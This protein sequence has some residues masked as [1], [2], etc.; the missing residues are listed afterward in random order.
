MLKQVL[1]TLILGAALSAAAPQ[2]KP[3][4]DN[5]RV[6]KRDQSKS[7]PTAD[8]GKNNTSDLKLMQQ[9]RK[10]V[11]DDK[12]LSTYA[13]NVK[14]I[15]QGGKITLKGPVRSEEEKR[16]VEEK[17][18]AVAGAGNVTNE[19]SIKAAANAETKATGTTKSNAARAKKNGGK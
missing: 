8:Q 5:T 16:S 14:I 15:A 7:E 18:V 2:D 6:N 9:I 19:I 12:S 11:I 13:H 17:A 1:G 10:S 3:A 4:P